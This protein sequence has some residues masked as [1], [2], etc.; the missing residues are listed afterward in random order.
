MKKNFT[1]KTIPN[2]HPDKEHFRKLIENE[3]DPQKRQ[4]LIEEETA[5]NHPNRRRPDHE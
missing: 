2:T 1:P 4:E 3:K 5:H